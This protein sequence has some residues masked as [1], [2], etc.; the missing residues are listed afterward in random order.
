[1]TVKSLV[2]RSTS[3]WILEKEVG[4]VVDHVRVVTTQGFRVAVKVFEA[5]IAGPV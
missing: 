2:D 1:M 3:P 5:V 4:L